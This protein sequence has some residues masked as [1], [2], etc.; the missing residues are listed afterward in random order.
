[1]E[2]QAADPDDSLIREFI[3]GREEAFSEILGRYKNLVLNVAYRFLRNRTEAEDVAQDVFLKIYRSARTYEPKA[4]F[5]TW[6]YKIT[7]NVCLNRL[8]NEKNAAK[9]VS[10]DHQDQADMGSSPGCFSPSEE[11][12]RNERLTVVHD[13]LHCLPANQRLAIVLKR[14]EGLSYREIAE[15]IGCSPAAVDSLLQRA[16]GKLRKYL[17]PYFA[18]RDAFRKG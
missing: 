12:E 8:R 4:K 2:K 5:S 14:Y 18:N 7:A 9:S 16:N 1:V 15:I 17:E 10:Y 3:S 6:V 11:L 13:A